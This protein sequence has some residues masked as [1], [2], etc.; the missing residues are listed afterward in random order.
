[1]A[2]SSVNGF[3]S[4]WILSSQFSEKQVTRTEIFLIE[5]GIAFSRYTVLFLV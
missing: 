2:V 4:L 3:G 5:S 1:M